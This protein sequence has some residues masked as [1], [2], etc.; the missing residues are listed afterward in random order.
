MATEK[1]L[2]VDDEVKYE[3]IE[4][5]WDWKTQEYQWVCWCEQKDCFEIWDTETIVR[6]CKIK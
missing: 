4:A 5:Q 3:I 6:V 2:I 1:V